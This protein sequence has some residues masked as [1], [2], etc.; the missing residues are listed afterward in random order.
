[1]SCTYTASYEGSLRYSVSIGWLSP[2]TDQSSSYLKYLAVADLSTREVPYSG[3][4]DHRN[5]RTSGELYEYIHAYH[6]LSSSIPHFAEV[7]HILRNILGEAY[8]KAISTRKMKSISK[9]QLSDLSWNEIY[10]NEFQ[11]M[12]QESTRLPYRD[13]KNSSVST[14]MQ[15]TS[16]GLLLQP[17][18]T[19]MSSESLFSIKIIKL[20]HL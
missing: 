15:R 18:S 1:M 9:L 8:E 17:R 4:I 6:L 20:L 11:T 13:P 2:Y 14:Q 10:S 5:L 7:V 12:L 16:S 19:R 3:L